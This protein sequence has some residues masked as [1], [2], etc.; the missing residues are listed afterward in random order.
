MENTYLL[1]Y[2]KETDGEIFI[3]RL[4]ANKIKER[5]QRLK[6]HKDDYTIIDGIVIK[7]FGKEIDY[8]KLK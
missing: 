2:M 7:S 3:E 8:S 6:L 4:T 5:I 1:I